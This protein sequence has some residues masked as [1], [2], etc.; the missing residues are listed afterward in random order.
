MKNGF[1][2]N[3]VPLNQDMLHL[4][5]PSYFGPQDW[6]RMSQTNKGF[7]N[8]LAYLEHKMLDHKIQNYLTGEIN[9][10]TIF[11]SAILPRSFADPGWVP[12]NFA[13]STIKSLTKSRRIRQLEP[14]ALCVHL[15]Y[16]TD[17]SEHE[18]AI[19]IA[20]G[21]QA[22]R[23]AAETLAVPS[24][25]N[26]ANSVLQYMMQRFGYTAQEAKEIALEGLVQL[27]QLHISRKWY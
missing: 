15:R 14:L 2:R 23:Y 22:T 13:T 19:S 4:E 17:C 21:I 6:S 5:I 1:G 27:L 24:D 18:Y 10:F 16:G 25:L 20:N 11:K 3:F 9:Y 8:G 7:K 26:R 12:P